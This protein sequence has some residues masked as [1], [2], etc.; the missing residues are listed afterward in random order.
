MSM[1]MTLG[2]SLSAA[3]IV[4]MSASGCASHRTR[5]T[6][7]AAPVGTTKTAD[8]AAHGRTTTQTDN[9]GNMPEAKQDDVDRLAAATATFNEVMSVPDKGIPKE[10]LDRAQCA[11]VVPGMKEGCLHR[12]GTVRQR[13]F[14]LPRY[15]G[16]GLDRAGL[17]SRRGRQLRLP[18][19]RLG[20]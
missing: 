6:G 14:L 4:A 16:D 3:V 10:L 18:D 19:R 15:I 8:S 5:A 20:D 7:G 11:V 12:R 17:G 9:S 1:R 2:V 13:L